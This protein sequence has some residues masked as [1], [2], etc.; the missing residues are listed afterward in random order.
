MKDK[1]RNDKIAENERHRFHDT[2]SMVSWI[3]PFRNW[4]ISISRL[5]EWR[6]PSQ[7]KSCH[8]PQDNGG[9][10]RILKAFLVMPGTLMLFWTCSVERQ[11]TGSNS[12]TGSNIR[13]LQHLQAPVDPLA[14]L[15]HG[16]C[17]PWLSYFL[18]PGVPRNKS[19]TTSRFLGLPK[20]ALR[21]RRSPAGSDRTL[22]G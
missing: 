21:I 1:T 10:R 11:A 20:K 3:E 15:V 19:K 16:C 2:C 8:F 12:S 9:L 4:R 5:A 7:I 18:S 14:L 13:G 17:Y 22:F 6:L